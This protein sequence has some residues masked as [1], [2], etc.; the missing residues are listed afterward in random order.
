[1]FLK[2]FVETIIVLYT[3]NFPLSTKLDGTGTADD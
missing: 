2:P 1:M 3:G